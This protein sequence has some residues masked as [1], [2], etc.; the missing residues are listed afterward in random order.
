MRT[1]LTLLLLS[2]C[3]PK[4][5]HN[6]ELEAVLQDK[7]EAQTSLQLVAEQLR[8]AQR[9]LAAET[10]ANR[11]LSER[12]VSLDHNNTEL[13]AKLKAIATELAALSTR[14]A[15]QAKQKASLETMLQE[16]Q[17]SADEA[18]REAEEASARAEKLAEE[19]QQLAEEAAKLQAEKAKLQQ[20]TQEYD[21]LLTELE[22]EIESGQVKITELSGKL[23]VNMSNAILF[24]SGSTTVKPAGKQ[25]LKKIAAVLATIDDR[26]I[27]V[28]GHT[29][30]VPVGAGASYPDNWA[31]SA[32]RASGVVALLIEGGVPPD[33]IAAVG[34]GEFRPAVPNDTKEHRAANRRTEIVLIPKLKKQ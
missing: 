23:T 9:S 8:A 31:L 3:V 22:Q 15:S 21:H 24:S 6:R 25:A 2:A 29:D 32:L 7:A 13:T 12:V 18:Q 19:R 17:Q 27:R 10:K 11:A 16:V 14:S 30:N 20:K 34:Y 28:E 26:D 1:L 5:K 4:A 33:H